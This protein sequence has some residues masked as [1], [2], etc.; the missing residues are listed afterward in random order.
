MNLLDLSA[1]AIPTGFQKNGLPFG[2][3]VC[4]PAFRDMQLLGLADRVQQ[5]TA[6]KL[7]ATNTPFTQ[8]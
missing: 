6:K 5:K 7:G 3:T 1:V 4:A 8:H 2:I